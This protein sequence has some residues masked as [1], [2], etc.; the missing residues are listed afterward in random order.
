MIDTTSKTD[1]LLKALR[2]LCIDPDL[3]VNVVDMGFVREARVD[4]HGVAVVAMTLCSNVCPLGKVMA[5]QA[6]SA[7]VGS[8]ASDL[9]L[10]WVW[11]PAWNPADITDAGR[12]RLAEI[13]FSGFGS[14]EVTSIPAS[15][16]KPD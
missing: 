10:E 12:E 15:P 4:E 13:G 1:A 7:I 3:G 14:L 11:T 8:V 16:V 5:D 2:G 6:R 9:R